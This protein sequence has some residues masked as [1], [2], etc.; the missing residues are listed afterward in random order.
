MGDL[1][2]KQGWLCYIIFIGSGRKTLA[3]VNKWRRIIC[4]Q[5]CSPLVTIQKSDL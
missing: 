1:M 5:F 3:F 4:S 2:S